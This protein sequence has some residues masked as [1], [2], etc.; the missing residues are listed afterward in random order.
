[1]RTHEITYQGQ[2]AA[3]Y[4]EIH[5]TVE[6]ASRS[7]RLFTIR[8]Q[9]R[10]VEND[11]FGPLELN[12]GHEV[13]VLKLDQGPAAHPNRPVLT[14]NHETRQFHH[15]Q[16]VP[17]PQRA[18]ERKFELLL[19][20]FAAAVFLILGSLYG[21]FLGADPSPLMLVGGFAVA[22]ILLAVGQVRYWRAKAAALHDQELVK[23]EKRIWQEIMARHG[24]L[25]GATAAP[26]APV[27]E[28]TYPQTNAD[29][30]NP[31]PR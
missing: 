12:P 8:S 19:W 1:M 23:E 10:E 20:M 16:A 30:R 15:Q 2:T 22:A 29:S 24:P 9:G 11:W 17:S 27:A 4:T 13:T 25:H 6:V 14:I 28:R 3:R 26:A 18:T 21:G 5:G 7:N 31:A